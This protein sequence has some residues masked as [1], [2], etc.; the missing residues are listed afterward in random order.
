MNKIFSSTIRESLLLWTLSFISVSLIFPSSCLAQNEDFN[1]W[2]AFSFDRK[3][4]K[5]TYLH[6]S[7]QSRFIENVT[8][9]NFS[10]FDVGLDKK[11]NK[12]FDFTVAYVFNIKRDLL[13]Y[14]YFRHQLYSN[15]TYD[16]GFG[17]FK[18][19]NRFRI[20]S[21]LDDQLALYTNPFSVFFYRNKSKCKFE[22]SKKTSLYVSYEWYYKI[23]NRSMDDLLIHRTRTAIGVC[24]QL[25]KRKK[26]D[27]YFMLQKQMKNNQLVNTYVLGSEYA[28]RIKR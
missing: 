14:W 25:K 5:D 1:V 17:D 8:R 9:Y 4:R 3:L 11:L 6:F 20:Q 28:L 26:I 24:N 21:D 16:I 7:T 10:F 18:F 13:D 15:V 23:N 2:S 12:H 27:V 19:S 22:L